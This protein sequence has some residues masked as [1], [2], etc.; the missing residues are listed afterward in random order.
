MGAVQIFTALS[1][2]FCSSELIVQTE[3]V[4]D[5]VKDF[6]A[7]IILTEIDNWIGDYFLNTSKQM[8]IYARDYVTQIYVLKKNEYFRYTLA[9]LVLDGIYLFTFIISIIPIYDSVTFKST[10]VV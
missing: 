8:Q 5:C 2:Y 7:L 4:I 10:P 3:T 9:D 1:C 6:S